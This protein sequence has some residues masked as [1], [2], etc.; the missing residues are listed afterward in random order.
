MKQTQLL[1]PTK[2]KILNYLLERRRTAKELAGILDVQVSATRKHLETMLEWKIV[3]EQFE[4][5]GFGRPKKFYTL[6]EE[7]RELFPRQYETVLN[8]ILKRLGDGKAKGAAEA[9]VRQVASDIVRQLDLH[10][11]GSRENM[12]LLT[13][14]LNN[15]GFD[16]SLKETRADYEVLSHNCPL[17]KTAMA[18]PK[19]ICQDLHSEIIKQAT[20]SRN[21]KLS[22]CVMSGDDACRHV[23]QK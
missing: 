10:G 21:V 3:G 13:A 15:F 20:H 14:G 16:A 1:G 7:G 17:H 12:E 19:L 4:Q 11:D 23:I 6:T 22:A 5:E 18:H 9:M 8:V 2:A